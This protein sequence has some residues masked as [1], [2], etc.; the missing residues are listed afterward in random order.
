M[1]YE[2]FQITGSSGSFGLL[3]EAAIAAE[4]KFKIIYTPEI[5][6]FRAFINKGD[7]MNKKETTRFDALYKRHLMRLKLQ[8]KSKGT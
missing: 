4:K 2:H 7:T 5:A 6:Q 8:G 1:V 3:N